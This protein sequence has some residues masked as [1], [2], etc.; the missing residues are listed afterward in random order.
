MARQALPGGI[1]RVPLRWS[2]AR[3]ADLSVFSLL[4]RPGQARVASYL[5]LGE[6]GTSS[7]RQ[8]PC[9]QPKRICTRRRRNGAFAAR[10]QA[11]PQGA[12]GRSRAAGTRLSGAAGR[13]RTIPP[14][15]SASGPAGTA[16][17]PC[18]AR[19]PRRTSWRSPRR[20]ATIATRR[21]SRARSTWARTRTRSRGPRNGPRSRCWRQTTWR[22]SSSAT[23]ASRRR[24]RSPTPSSSITAGAM[25]G[26][27]TAS[28]SRPRTIRRRTAA[29]STIRPMAGR[30]I[31]M[32]P[33]GS[34][35]APTRCCATA[36]RA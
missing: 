20:S 18:A 15:R 13:I 14:S 1:R 11:G 9:V 4:A 23:T 8:R 34:R 35:I 29:S 12:A 27:P 31:P 30:P 2:Q 16:D 33:G 24:R 10:R 6:A 26:W 28:W 22:P 32:S 5:A 19:S 25:T 36:M 3:A 7:A 17:H 21:P